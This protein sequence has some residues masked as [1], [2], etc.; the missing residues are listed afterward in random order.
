[1]LRP[2][3]THRPGKHRK[4]RRLHF[5]QPNRT[6]RKKKGR[7]LAPAPDVAAC[8]FGASAHF[9]SLPLGLAVAGLARA[10]DGAAVDLAPVLRAGRGEYDLLA[11]DPAAGDRRDDIPVLQGARHEL[12]V[13]LERELA[14]PELPGALDLGRDDPEVTAA[15]GRAAV[16]GG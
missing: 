8:Y 7:R 2:S 1:M 6:K 3:R 12:I 11:R 14:V 13:L 9:G 5:R 16:R 4:V 10:I 15:V